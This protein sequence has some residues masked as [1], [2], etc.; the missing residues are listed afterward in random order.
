MTDT[1]TTPAHDTRAKILELL[2]ALPA[3]IKETIENAEVSYVSAD[4]CGK[5]ITVSYDM[6]EDSICMAD[7]ESS[8]E[9][10]RALVDSGLDRLS[11]PLTFEARAHDI[12]VGLG[13]LMREADEALS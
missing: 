9:S 5:E 10:I 2:E 11:P 3:I 7:I 4:V 8:L 6:D 13:G 12:L 1:H